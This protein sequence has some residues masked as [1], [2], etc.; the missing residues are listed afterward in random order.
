MRLQRLSHLQQPCYRLRAWLKEV[1]GSIAQQLHF[2]Q[3]AR[4]AVVVFH[5]LRVPVNVFFSK[6]LM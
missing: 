6:F 5:S 2:V 3:K 4:L 1:I